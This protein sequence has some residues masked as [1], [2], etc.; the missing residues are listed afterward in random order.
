MHICT[1]SA[2][3]RKVHNKDNYWCVAHTAYPPAGGW[4][5]VG[6]FSF[7]AQRAHA[8]SANP[9][10][11]EILVL[12][13]CGRTPFP[14]T[15]PP[16]PRNPTSPGFR[17]T[18]VSQDVFPIDCDVV[19]S[20]SCGLAR[21]SPASALHKPRTLTSFKGGRVPWRLPPVRAE[22][23]RSR[24]SD[25]GGSGLACRGRQSLGDFSPESSDSG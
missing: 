10:L 22:P 3:F 7:G 6:T 5:P 23:R 1:R 20:E 15:Q 8:L 13:R 18:L 19:L 9:G 2:F 17:Q 25:S 16:F 24:C 21:G 12:P 14:L 4:Y 11:A